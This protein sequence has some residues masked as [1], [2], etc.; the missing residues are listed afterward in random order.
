MSNSMNRPLLSCIVLAALGVGGFAGAIVAP[1]LSSGATPQVAA[2]SA[3]PK[4]VRSLDD[5]TSEVAIVKSRLEQLELRPASAPPDD[6]DGA[7][8]AT[9]REETPAAEPA[10]K[11]PA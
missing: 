5:L 11:A 7:A 1:V 4:L 6:R 3:D 9:R 10:A 2:A 8:A